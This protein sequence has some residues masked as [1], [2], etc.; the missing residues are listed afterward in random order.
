MILIFFNC[1]TFVAMRVALTFAH[2][3]FSCLSYDKNFAFREGQVCMYPITFRY[4]EI[5]FYAY[6]SDIHENVKILPEKRIS[7]AA[8]ASCKRCF[9]YRKEPMMP[10]LCLILIKT[11]FL[12]I[13]YCLLHVLIGK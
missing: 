11:D 1:L 8:S 10:S 2:F 3:L 12:F 13:F 4:H 6:I 7:S 9:L 5:S